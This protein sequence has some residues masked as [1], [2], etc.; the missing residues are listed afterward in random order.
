MREFAYKGQGF[1]QYRIGSNGAD[2]SLNKR[3]SFDQ[4]FAAWYIRGI[5]CGLFVNVCGFKR[6]FILRSRDARP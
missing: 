3:G 2:V 4:W 5:D 6:W 1:L